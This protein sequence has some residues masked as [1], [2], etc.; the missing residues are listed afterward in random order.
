MLDINL[1]RNAPRKVVEALAKRGFDLDLS[2]FLASDEKRRELIHKTE[3]LKAERNAKSK[4]VPELKRAGEDATEL[5]AE[6]KELA[7]QIKAM[8]DE[9]TALNAEQLRFIEALPNLP[10]EHVQAG[11]KEANQV[12][13]SAG[14]KPEFD[15]E[16]KHHVDLAKDL[17]LIDYERGAKLSGNGYWLYTGLGA[18]LEWALLNYF[19][20]SHIKDGYEMIL[21]PH[22]LLYDCGYT[23]GQFPKFNDDV[24]CLG[25][26]DALSPRDAE[27][28]RDFSHFLLPTSETA[29]INL[30][31][32]EILDE[33]DL[34]KKFFAYTP[35]YRREAGSYRADERGMIRGHQFNKV[36]MFQ[37]TK[38]EDSPAA[39]KELVEKAE[40]L[41]SELGL[42]YQ[43]S[44]LA[45][46]DVSAS[47]QETYDIE[48]WIPSMNGYKEVSSASCAGEYQARRGLIRFRREGAKKPEYL[49]SLNASGL[50]TSRVFPAILEQ[51]Q[52][53]DGSV[54]VPEVLR[55]YMGGL[56]II[57]KQK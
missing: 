6:M 38:P 22:L 20:D 4:Q 15:F 27:L 34:P 28:G 56:E 57:A 12:L 24:F 26:A 32:D 3:E 13:S 54:I 33:K 29:L 36:E 25:G 23:A 21:P 45:A 51:Y 1:L 55:P 19:I 52:Q 46:G 16:P 5:L 9:L 39:L 10:A 53:A 41:V 8:D 30:Y 11:G 35:C 44:R 40:R 37:F 48:V 17:G 7:D 14:E 2:D 47:M 49:H 18:R 43:V 42:H 31:R 50:A